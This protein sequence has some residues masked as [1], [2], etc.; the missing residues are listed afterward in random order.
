MPDTDI[1]AAVAAHLRRFNDAV[2]SGDFAGLVATFADD[3][4]MSFDGVP[5]GPFRGRAEILRAYQQ[6]PPTSTMT[7]Q[8]IEEIAPGLARV[9]FEWDGG[10]TGTM[11]VGF[12]A[13]RVTELR[14]AFD[15]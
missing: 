12:S 6:Q 10:G 13:D 11:Q 4:V 2:R 3:A 15:D 7:A 8:S 9:R 5:I 1:D 14:V